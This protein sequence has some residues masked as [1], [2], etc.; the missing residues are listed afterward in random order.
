MVAVL[1]FAVL[2]VFTGYAFMTLVSKPSYVKLSKKEKVLLTGREKFLLLT[3]V[4]GMVQAGSFSALRLMLW[5]AMI[6]LAFMLYRKPP[7]F[8]RLNMVYIVFLFWLGITMLWSPDLSYAMRAYLKYLYPLLALFFA[9]V[10]V[11]SKDFIFVAMRWM[12]IVSFVLS[13]FLG[14]F[15]IHSVG[16]IFYLYGMFWPPSTLADYLAV[17]SAAS[18]VMWWRTGEK[19]YLLLIGWFLL[20]DVTTG[21][22]TGILSI[23]IMLMAGSYLRYK[24][25]SLP[26]LAAA[27]VIGVAAILFVPQVKNK[28][29][30]DP[31]KVQSVGDIAGAVSGNNVN[32]NMRGYM[33]A[34]LLA[35]FYVGHEGTGS[36]LGSVQQYMYE[37]Y[38]FG[39]LQVPHSDYVQM[40]CDSGNAAVLLYLLFPIMLYFYTLKY[41]HKKPTTPIG[42]SAVL[43]VLAYAAVLPAMGFDN[44]VNYSFASH[45]YPFMFAGIFLAYKRMERKANV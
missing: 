38:V 34:H 41:V 14:G 3:L 17:M 23:G 27:L 31:A 32:T 9:A 39:G 44:V 29:F 22:R 1:H 8:N 18:F 26:Y 5:M 37:N 6:V 42:A 16:F 15:A 43:A 12:L 19:K 35:Q 45:S 4:T 30:F 25:L 36:G 7:R 2:I 21:I 13:V 20:S 10:F 33:W 28:M 11:Q 40:L 24:L